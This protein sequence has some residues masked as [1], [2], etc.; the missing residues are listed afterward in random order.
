MERTLIYMLSGSAPGSPARPETFTSLPRSM[1][2]SASTPQLVSAL[3]RQVFWI[4]RD[5]ARLHYH[6][7]RR[8]F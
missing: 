6:R 3:R 7:A 2:R 4:R 5:A 1:E 8:A